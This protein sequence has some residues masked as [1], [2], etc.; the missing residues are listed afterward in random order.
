MKEEFQVWFLGAGPGDPELLTLK[1]KRHIEEADLVLYTGSLVPREVVAFARKE[2][3]VIDSSPMT[4][5]ETHACIMETV[6]A[7]GKVARVHTGDPSLYG[8]VREQMALLDGEGVAY[9]VVPGVTAAFAAAAAAMVSF[10][11]PEKTQTLIVTR[12]GG[13]T[14]VSER[15]RLRELARHGSSMAIYL[16]AS[17]PEEMV[18]ELLEGGYPGETPVI[19]GYRVGWPDQALYCT[20][21]RETAEI[22]VKNAINRQAVFLILPTQTSGATVSRLYSPEFGHGRRDATP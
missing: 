16:S 8:A 17:K 9:Q 21:L 5:S 14:P 3:K 12:L 13:R 10:T 18:A 2:A 4:L 7:G 15:E 22:V 1:A 6:R 11:I 20:T 19:I